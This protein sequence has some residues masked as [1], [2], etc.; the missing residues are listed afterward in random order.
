MIKSLDELWEKIQGE[1]DKRFAEQ[2]KKWDAKFKEQDKKWEGR[3]AEQD[4]KAEERNKVVDSRF[5]N[6]ENMLDMMV[7]VNLAKILNEQTKTRTELEN[8]RIELKNDLNK[9][10]KQNEYEHKKMEC[11]LAEIE[12]KYGYTANQ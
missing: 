3:F 1:F 4:K 12:M 5:D 7:N 11:K 6:I 2:D 9:Y 10:I 8:T